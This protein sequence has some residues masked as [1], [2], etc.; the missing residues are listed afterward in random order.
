M[1]V[2]KEGQ[3]A[4]AD[5]LCLLTD[6]L[7]GRPSDREFHVHEPCP[8]AAAK[9]NLTAAGPDGLALKEKKDEARVAA[10]WNAERLPDSVDARLQDK[11]EVVAFAP[12]EVRA[13]RLV[14]QTRQ[15]EA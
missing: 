4:A 9:L 7:V 2:G 14:G 8:H 10:V 15:G 5:P 1:P 12:P 3:T 11:G 13:Q 6:E